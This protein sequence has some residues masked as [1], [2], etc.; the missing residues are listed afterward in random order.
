MKIMQRYWLVF[1]AL[2]GWA[3]TGCVKEQEPRSL[4]GKWRV[5]STYRMHYPEMGT[6]TPEGVVVNE[7]TVLPCGKDDIFVIMP[8]ELWMEETGTVCNGNTAGARYENYHWTF[9][10]NNTVLALTGEFSY[11]YYTS[12]EILRYDGDHLTLS[13]H[14]STEPVNGQQSGYIVRTRTYTRIE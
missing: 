3:L 4:V 13:D 7:D 1:P 8:D 5:D 9:A 14:Y 11:G 6:G 12:K 2:L 10:N